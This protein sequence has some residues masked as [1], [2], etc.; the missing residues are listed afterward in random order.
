[1]HKR[2]NTLWKT[3]KRDTP[4]PVGSG[5]TW[6]GA[7]SPWVENGYFKAPDV[8]RILPKGLSDLSRLHFLCAARLLARVSGPPLEIGIT[9]STT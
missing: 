8:F 7:T 6:V 2:A 9:W 1:M 5:V 4:K 3:F